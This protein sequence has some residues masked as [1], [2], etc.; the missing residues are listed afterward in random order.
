MK[1]VSKLPEESVVDLLNETVAFPKV[2]VTEWE[3]TKP[4]PV[5]VIEEP[6]IPLVELR[7]MVE[8]VQKEADALFNP[9]LTVNV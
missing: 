1:V 5:T 9:S 6:T 7:L 4:V 2:A 3:P 8:V